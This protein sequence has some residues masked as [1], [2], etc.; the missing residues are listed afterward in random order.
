[1]QKQQQ[2]Q[3][4]IQRDLSSDEL[5]AV[6]KEAAKKQGEELKREQATSV[7]TMDDAYSLARELGIPEEYVTEAAG[8][9]DARRYTDLRV[10]QLRGRR[11]IQF[12]AAAGIGAV[13]VGAIWVLGLGGWLTFLMAAGLAGLIA[14]IAL[15]RWLAVAVGDVNLKQI[16]PAPVPGRCRVCGQAAVT[17]ESTFCEEHRYKSP[18]E[19]KAS[20]E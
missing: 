14:L 19:L 18:A 20:R 6:I 3:R 10:G 1:M 4:R 5:A 11:M 8:D 12:L 15:V 9:L 2:Q 16:G 7:T 13:V 17:P